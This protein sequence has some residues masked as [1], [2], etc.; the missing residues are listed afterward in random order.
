MS[1]LKACES[2]KGTD[3]KGY[4]EKIENVRRINSD[5]IKEEQAGKWRRNRKGKVIKGKIKNPWGESQIHI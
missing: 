1:W 5:R 4:I 3:K 2:E